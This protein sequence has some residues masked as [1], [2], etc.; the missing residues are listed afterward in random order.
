MAKAEEVRQYRVSYRFLSTRE[1]FYGTLTSSNDRATKCCMIERWQ[2]S[3]YAG[4][5]LICTVKTPSLMFVFASAMEFA[6]QIVYLVPKI[7]PPPQWWG[8]CQN[9]LFV[10]LNLLPLWMGELSELRW[11][12]VSWS[13]LGWPG[14]TLFV[15]STRPPKRYISKQAYCPRGQLSRALI[16]VWPHCTWFPIWD[17]ALTS[18]SR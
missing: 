12:E 8:S 15:P 7:P 9:S 18:P 11:A 13:E 5:S 4:T 1:L 16:F 2:N 14:W 10:N 17:I 3:D 6:I